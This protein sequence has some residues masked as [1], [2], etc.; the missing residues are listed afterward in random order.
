MYLDVALDKYTHFK[1]QIMCLF[2]V[3]W[4]TREDHERKV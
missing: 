1:I 3:I 2:R 4:W